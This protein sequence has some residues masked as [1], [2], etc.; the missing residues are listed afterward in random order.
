MNT[1]QK[2]TGNLLFFPALAKTAENRWKA[3]SDAARNADISLPHDAETVSLLSWVFALSDFVFKTASRHPEVLSDLIESGELFRPMAEGEY[4]LRMEEALADVGDEADLFRR[5][6][7]IRQ[8]EIIRIAVR[9]LS[10][11][12]DLAET[13]KELSKFADA[14]I[15]RALAHLYRMTCDLY[16]VPADRNGEIQ[17]LV[18]M[19]MGKLGADEL[20]FSSDIDLIFAYP[21]EG[22]TDGEKSV[23]NGEFFLKLCRKLLKALGE[24]T[25]D[26]SVFRVDTALRPFGES[27]PL[28]MSFDGMENYYQI[29]GREWERYAWIKA[30]PAAGDKAAGERLLKRLNPFIYRRYLDFGVFES[31]REMKQKIASEVR[32]K[33]LKGNIKLGA[34]GIR[35]IEF[36]GQVFQLIRGGVTPSLQER[37]IL[38]VLAALVREKILEPE[39]KKELED[40][41]LFLRMTENRLQE[42]VDA[43]THTLP[44]DSAGRAR[45]A[46]AMGFENVKGYEET[47]SCHMRNVSSHFASLLETDEESPGD[48]DADADFFAALWSKSLT[49]EKSREGLIRAGFI[50]ADEVLSRLRGFREGPTTGSL[51]REGRIRLDRLMPRVMRAAADSAVP[52]EALVRLIELLSGIQ[53][54][55]CYLSLL[56]ENPSTLPHLVQFAGTSAWM[57]SF[58]ARHPVLLDELLDTRTL[59]LPPARK[60]LE[61]ELTERLESI[62]PEDLERQMEVL[63]IFKQVNILRVAAADITHA[64]PL[65]RVSDHLSDIAETLLESVF[66]ISWNHLT[67]KHGIPSLQAGIDAEDRGF[68][69]IAYGK[70]GGF[71]LSY[72][73]DLDLVFLHGG[74]SAP[75]DGEKS[76]IDSSYF[77]ARLGQ[78]VIH[79][80]TAHTPAGILYEADMRLR[81]SGGAGML[82]SRIDAFREYQLHEAW[83]WEKQALIRARPV[84]GDPALAREFLSI[85]REVLAQPQDPEK[86]KKEVVKMRH[87]MKKE[88][89]RPSP[90]IFDLKQ[91]EGGVVDVEFIVQYLVLLHAHRYPDLLDWTDN[92]RLIGKLAAAGV[93][94]DVSA[95]LLR[96]TY[97]VYRTTGHRL[98]LQKKPAAVPEEQFSAMRKIVQRFWSRYFD[99]T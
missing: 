8:R 33:E 72:D 39:V 93:I 52:S 6:R 32:R 29:E 75:T 69:G 13:L 5:L 24:K 12:A 68:V 74:S 44:G 37:K 43:Q 47:L 46:A 41:Y 21:E 7:Q 10:G 9:D 80:L 25:A 4:V 88:L 77:F 56:L 49:P 14:C 87:R 63:R 99:A 89:H 67:G 27:G 82:V 2:F 81:P 19:G 34:G 45:L 15:D 48:A 22:K 50:D 36:F 59:Y 42:F 76:P 96:K 35:E 84:C 64:L 90:G 3:F 92:V 16:G 98:S 97:L 20:N 11:M 31:L 23:T 60:A 83:T 79:L 40:A 55:T 94:D 51:S 91:G 18:V 62:D 53:R 58:L 86:L 71:E 17:Q 95:Y 70:L 66:D 57:L 65:M 73:S 85:R 38:E 1:K 61:S 26:G 78:R 54:R 28:V 30:R